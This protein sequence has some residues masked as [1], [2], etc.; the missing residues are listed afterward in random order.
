MLG[1]QIYRFVSDGGN[2]SLPFLPAGVPRAER[3]GTRSG[4][5]L[6]RWS[7]LGV[8]KIGLNL[9]SQTVSPHDR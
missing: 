9:N 5:A 2:R 3:S 1:N 7:A 4:G 6:N 8:F